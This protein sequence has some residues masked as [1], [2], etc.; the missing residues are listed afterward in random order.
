MIFSKRE[1]FDQ[2]AKGSYTSPGL[3][4]PTNDVEL[5]F[6]EWHSKAQLLEEQYQQP[7]DDKSSSIGHAEHFY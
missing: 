5:S 1:S 2:L 7:K 3:E 4:P 6:A